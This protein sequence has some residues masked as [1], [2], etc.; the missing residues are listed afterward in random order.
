MHKGWDFSDFT[1]NAEIRAIGEGTVIYANH[2]DEHLYGNMVVVEH[3]HKDVTFYSIY[4]HF[5]DGQYVS[6]GQVV[7]SDTILGIQ[8]STGDD[9]LPDKYG[10][11]LHFQTA[12]NVDDMKAL[13]PD[14]TINKDRGTKEKNDMW[15]T[16]FDPFTGRMIGEGNNGVTYATGLEGGIYGYSNYQQGMPT[17]TYFIE[18]GYI[19]YEKG[20]EYF[21]GDNTDE[22][23]E[24][25]S[26]HKLWYESNSDIGLDYIN[27]YDYVD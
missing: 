22:T 9:N 26:N 2:G 27:L 1:G 8:G 16:A 12:T 23:N 15:N 11:H 5:E 19:M 24:Y 21:P 14:G 17:G 7:S 4:M 18:Q 3:T 6:E 13:N 25:Y 10:D 20:S